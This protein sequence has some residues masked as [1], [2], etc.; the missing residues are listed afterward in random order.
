MDEEENVF[1]DCQNNNDDSDEGK[2]GNSSNDTIFVDNL[3]WEDIDDGI[4]I[5]V[6]PDRYCGPHGLK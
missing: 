5:P 6:I 4:V 3:V 2:D 1:G